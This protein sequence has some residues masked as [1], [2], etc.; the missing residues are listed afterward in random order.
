M[1]NKENTQRCA[2]TSKLQTRLEETVEIMKDIVSE[3]KEG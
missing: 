2:S 3:E 1:V